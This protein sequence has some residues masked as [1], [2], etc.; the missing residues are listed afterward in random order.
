M[1]LPFAKFEEGAEAYQEAGE[2]T[3]SLR[4]AEIASG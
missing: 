4:V 1:S 3:S 2:V